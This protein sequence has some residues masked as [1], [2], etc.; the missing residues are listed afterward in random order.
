ML[1]LIT[2]AGIITWFIS[3]SA[4]RIAVASAIALVLSQT[5]DAVVYQL[6]RKWP[7]I[8]RVMGSNAVGAVV[9]S[10]VFPTIAFGG[11]IW[12]ATLG[13]IVAKVVGGLVWYP[14]VYRGK[15]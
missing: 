1:C 6:G 13:Q 4:G 15:A 11:F 9:D 14:V 10:F 8:R 3:R 12:W 7:R 2:V 5:A